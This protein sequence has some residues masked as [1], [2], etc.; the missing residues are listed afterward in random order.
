[1]K[2]IKILGILFAIISA[3]GV[4]FLFN[5][6]E[7]TWSGKI[8]NFEAYQQGDVIVLSWSYSG[9]KPGCGAY[10]YRNDEFLD[11]P[12]IQEGDNCMYVDEAPVEGMNLYTI[13]YKEPYYYETYAS[14]STTVYF[15]KDSNN[16]NGNDNGGNNDDTGNN[17]DNNLSSPSNVNA[18]VDGNRVKV[19]WSSV[20]GANGYKIY[21]AS[22]SNGYFEKIGDSNSTSYYDN[23][24]MDG[25]NYYRIKAYNSSSESEYSS[26]AYCSYAKPE[27]VKKPSAPTGV[28]AESAGPPS[29]QYVCITWN[30][31][32]NATSYKVYRA[33]S[34]NGYYSQI[35]YET[36]KA[37]SYDYD[38]ELGTNYYKVKAINSAGESE[39]SSYASCSC[40]PNDVSPCPVQ[41]GNCSAT[42]TT[43]TLRWTNPTTSGCG[44]PDK[45]ILRV[46]HPD[47]GQYADLETL[48]GTATSASFSFG[49]WLDDNGYV[50][51][52]I[53]TENEHGSSGGVPK[54]YDYNNKRWIN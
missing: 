5:A 50:Y 10:I 45:A 33:T 28:T 20:S 54:V 42:S 24:P 14:A 41:Y 52:G 51:C 31:V 23:Y 21:R 48:P 32:E 34:A 29:A 13:E 15:T 16:G 2:S 7:E 11:V 39:Y 37:L 4:C 12:Q 53:I 19:T 46:R 47:S 36:T 27:E 49:M 9:D 18:Y 8:E 35:G 1:M 43:I 30:E 26:Y 44:K 40:D 6:C 25:T 38:P 3:I 17:N 22:S